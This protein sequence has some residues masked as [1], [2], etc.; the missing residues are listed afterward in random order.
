[1]SLDTT[2]S[3]AKI[4]QTP[5]DMIGG[6]TVVRRIV[7]RF[8]DIMDTA[9]EATRLRAMHGDDLAPMRDRLS[10]FMNAWLGGPRTYF[11]RGDRKCIMTAHRPFAIG[12]EDSDAWM[13]CMRQ[14]L[15]DCDVPPKLRELVDRALSRMA[16][17]FRNR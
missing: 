3:N 15:E 12:K 17:A 7:D 16:T 11:E 4:E 10:E 9:P 6:A 14:A 1:M 8:Y 5:Y 2:T 13:M